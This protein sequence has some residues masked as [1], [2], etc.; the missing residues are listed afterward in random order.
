MVQLSV[1]EQD[2]SISSWT[3]IL[4]NGCIPALHVF[5]NFQKIPHCVH[6]NMMVSLFSS[7][8]PMVAEAVQEELESYRSQEDEVKRLKSAMVSAPMRVKS[9]DESLCN[10]E[11]HLC[12]E[13]YSQTASRDS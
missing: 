10:I 4:Q 5:P 7:P 13:A 12:K 1:T 9:H 11:A 3:N 2:Q 8:F 6:G